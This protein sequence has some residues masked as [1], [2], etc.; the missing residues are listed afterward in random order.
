MTVAIQE[1]KPLINLGLVRSHII[2]GFAFL[3]IAMLLGIFYA[4]QII[5]IR[6]PALSSSPQVV[7][8]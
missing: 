2:A 8:G 1:Q 3:I 6:F 4:L 5:C 7:S